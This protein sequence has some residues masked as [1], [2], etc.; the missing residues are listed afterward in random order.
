[1]EQPV[2]YTWYHALQTRLE[3]RFSH[4]YTFQLSYTYSKNMQ[5]TEFLNNTD[6]VPYRTIG[7]LD[8][9]HHL[10]SSFVWEL[11][12]G[13]GKRFSVLTAGWQLN[14]L[15][16]R[17]SGP[18]LG[19]GDVWTLFTGNPDNVN[20][21]KDKR[22][23][24][25]WFNTDA[26]FNKNTAQQ[27]ASNIRYSPL[28]FSGIRAD[29]QARWDFSAIKNFQIKERVKV[30]YRAEVLNAW[31]HPNLLTPNTTPTNTS[32]GAITGQDV[33]RAWQMSLKV[34]F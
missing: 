1:M 30:Q 12:F 27:L 34:K 28:R 16:Q 9:T 24:D 22:N 4:G 17:Q 8:R 5:A 10:V 3:K 11:P 6:P 32:F 33:P 7:D 15:V 21:P 20:L 2:G 25:R 18:P 13:R 29:G 19:F 26:G 23:V 31:N 14:G